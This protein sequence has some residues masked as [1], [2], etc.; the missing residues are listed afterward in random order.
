[1]KSLAAWL[2]V[3]CLMALAIEWSFRIDKTEWAQQLKRNQQW[4]ELAKGE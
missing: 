1:M 4:R 2:V 3:A